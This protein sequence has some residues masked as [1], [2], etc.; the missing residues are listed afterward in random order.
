M[1]VYR[2][3]ALDMFPRFSFEETVAKVEKLGTTRSVQGHM[4]HLRELRYK[5][6]A[7]ERPKT[8]DELAPDTNLED[9]KFSPEEER[10]EGEPSNDVICLSLTFAVTLPGRRV[11]EEPIVVASVPP[12]DHRTEEL[13]THVTQVQLDDDE[14]STGKFL[15]LF[16][17]EEENQ[18]T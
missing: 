13:A 14:E 8:F 6:T 18:D 17:Q 10:H 4:N 15:D 7:P 9:H 5:V 11:L 2:E 16:V 3:W 12:E 1:R